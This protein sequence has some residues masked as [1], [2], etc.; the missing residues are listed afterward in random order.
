MRTFESLA[1]DLEQ[2]GA[3]SSAEARRTFV[4]RLVGQLPLTPSERKWLNIAQQFAG[5]W[6]SQDDL[7]PARTEA[8]SSLAGKSCD[9]GDA[10]VNQRR[11]VICALYPDT[12]ASE[13]LDEIVNVKELFVTAG[14]SE[15]VAIEILTA[16]FGA[17]D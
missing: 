3:F 15:S 2:T 13:A 4:L 1:S 12:P 10:S 9:F 14:G 6:A 11:A 5:G 17:A 7:E 16:T 8:W